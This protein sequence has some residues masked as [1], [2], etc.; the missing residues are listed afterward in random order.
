[1]NPQP[2][3]LFDRIVCGVDETPESLEAVRQAVRL[4]NPDGTLHLF[5]AVYLAGAVA[6]GW[7]APRIAGEL[8]R[9]AGDALRRAQEVAGDGATSRLVNG[10]AV[11][12]L[13]E[14]AEREGATLLC[15]GSHERRRVEGILFDHVATTMLHEALCAVLVAREPPEP[16]AFPRAVVVGVDGSAHATAAYAAAAEL[17]ERF[18]A[19]VTPVAASGGG[20]DTD[21]LRREVPELTVVDARPV[22]A[23]LDAARGADLLVVGSRGLT[24]VRALGSI[25][26]RVAHRAG[27]SVLV[28]R[29]PG[30]GEHV[31]STD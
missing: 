31:R 3:S 15:V 1:V 6:A 17:A 7:S 5:S 23:L 9:E 29:G 13:L 12:S 11:R 2:P 19:T 14:E 21:V 4:R 30:I 16:G 20:V 18:G 8:E 24:G 10:P 28:V 26:E 27:C 25:S 22:D